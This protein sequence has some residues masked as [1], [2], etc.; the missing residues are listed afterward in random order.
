MAKCSKCG[1]DK[2]N[3]RQWLDYAT[4]TYKYLCG[5]CY[6]DVINKRKKGFAISSIIK[7]EPIKISKLKA[8]TISKYEYKLRKDLKKKIGKCE[9]CGT[10]ENLTI[11][12]YLPKSEGGKDEA[13]NYMVLCRGCHT[14]YYH[15]ELEKR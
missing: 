12:H 7:N 1:R 11:H 8:I 6:L 2:K 13:K 15:K 4:H 5:K 10:N 3:G 9:I 14:I